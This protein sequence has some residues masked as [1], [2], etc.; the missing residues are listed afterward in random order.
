VIKVTFCFDHAQNSLSIRVFNLRFQKIFCTMK[1]LI[2]T[3]FSENAHNAAK[4][5][6]GLFGDS[7]T[8][9]LVNAY[10]IP[11]SGSTMLISIADILKRDSE[12]LLDEQLVKLEDEFPYLSDAITV[13]AEM[14]LPEVVLKKLLDKG[15]DMV[16][17]GTKG[18]TGL[19]GV[20]LGS[21]AV[22]VIQ[23]VGYP[24]LS[25]PEDSS[26]LKPKLILF[27]S[28][29]LSLQR[30]KCP[31]ALQFI[32][33][34]S[35]ATIKILNILKEDQ[36]LPAENDAHVP[37]NV[38]GDL[39]HTYHFEK[40][41]DTEAIISKFATKHD[42]DLIVMVRRK[43]DL[44]ANLFGSSITKEMALHAKIPLLIIPESQS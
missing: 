20:L 40:G 14:G 6:L 43:N 19:K 15:Y 2:P 18:A 1:I 25:V 34:C 12:Q 38:F 7:A 35:N 11:H 44:F 30:D 41:N 27:A 5:A 16:V 13:K 21:V 8:Y 10:Q 32:A 29:N 36:H 31:D 17:M 22:S 3:D 23:N 39:P 42:I 28:D 33:R 24:V 9:T 4:Y 37:M 26:I